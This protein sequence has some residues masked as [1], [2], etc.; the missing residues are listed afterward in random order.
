MRFSE[1]IL[2]LVSIFHYLMK[3]NLGH[4]PIQLFVFKENFKTTRIILVL[5]LII[6]FLNCKKTPIF[7]FFKELLTSV[8]IY[9]FQI[10][11]LDFIVWILC[12]QC[13]KHPNIITNINQ[14]P[15]GL[16]IRSP[17]RQAPTETL[18]HSLVMG[19]ILCKVK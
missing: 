11:C 16:S 3:R 15:Y 14:N 10:V 1:K 12:S 4:V 5:D 9:L 8:V 13:F 19:N 17:A 2:L 18:F 7:S 6:I